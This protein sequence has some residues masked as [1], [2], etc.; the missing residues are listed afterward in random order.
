M[1]IPVNKIIE[2]NKRFAPPLPTE[3]D[4][5]KWGKH[6]KGYTPLLVGYE[7]GL[8]F[9]FD[10][11]QVWGAG[12]MYHNEGGREYLIVTN[13]KTVLSRLEEVEVY[14]VTD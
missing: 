6:K 11:E 3:E 4:F 2:L 5:E 1:I 8:Y 7:N 13:L 12:T 10:C 9:T 14:N